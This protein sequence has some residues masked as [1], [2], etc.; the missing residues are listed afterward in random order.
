MHH[1][2]DMPRISVEVTTK[3]AVESSRVINRRNSCLELE[4]VMV[5]QKNC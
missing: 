4:E 3:H 1:S 5:M 2:H